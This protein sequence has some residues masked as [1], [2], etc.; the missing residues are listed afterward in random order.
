M[1]NFY[2]RICPQGHIDITYR[3]AKE[4]C[5]RQ[6][7]GPLMDSC[8]QCGSIIKQWH[9]YG[10][11]YLTPKNLKF[12]R[13][14]KCPAC[15][16]PFPW[17]KPDGHAMSEIT[18][19]LWD[20][21]GTLL[22]F[23]ASEEECIRGCLAKYGVQISDEQMEWYS[24]CNHSYWKRLEAGEI[25]RMQVYLGRFEDF[26]D[27]IGVS[28]IP[29]E[30]LNDQYQEALGSSVVMQE[31]AIEICG[32]L[33][34]RYRQYVVTNGSAV[35]QR[36]K[37]KKSGLENFMDG[38]FISEEMGAEKPSREFFDMCSTRI[39]DYDPARTMIIGDSLTSD[40]AGGNNA[41][42]MCCWFNPD[43]AELTGQLRIDH[44]IR[45]LKEL[46]EIL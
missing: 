1:S 6:C 41:G 17:S 20:V 42:I 46:E 3:R 22:D 34:D 29:V 18:T 35:A 16:A 32:Y 33:K 10:M 30:Q 14:D 45:S 38:I 25:T 7:G 2:A 8:P 37:L 27:Y 11:V 26:F 12:Q 24:Q 19:V 39:P 13:P 44:E 4:E 5:C 28:H 21:D 31:N 9:Y 36:G 23:K 15:G 40:M 43:G